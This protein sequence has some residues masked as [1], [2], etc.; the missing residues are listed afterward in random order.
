M[1][2]GE[3]EDPCLQRSEAPPVPSPAVLVVRPTRRLRSWRV[4]SAGL[5]MLVL[6]AGC[7]CAVLVA[8][9]SADQQAVFVITG[10]AALVS[11]VIGYVRFGL[12]HTLPFRVLAVGALLGALAL[13]FPPGSVLSPLTS[14]VSELVIAVGLACAIRVGAIRNRDNSTLGAASVEVGVV[15]A[16][17]GAWFVNALPRVWS[18]LFGSA[19]LIMKFVV[20]PGT[21]VVLLV[22]SVLLL[23]RL[24]GSRG[25][26][27][28]A[29]A[30]ALE[31]VALTANIANVA[32][33][34]TVLAGKFFVVALVVGLVLTALAFLEPS[35][36]DLG[37]GL[38][39]WRSRRSWPRTA[40]MLVIPGWVIGAVAIG[41]SSASD[42]VWP[43]LLLTSI[44]L[45]AVRSR[46]IAGRTPTAGARRTSEEAVDRPPLTIDGLRAWCRSMP[47][48]TGAGL[49][50]AVIAVIPEVDLD[51]RGGRAGRV[52]SAVDDEA[53]RRLREVMAGA[54]RLDPDWGGQWEVGLDRDRFLVVR[55]RPADTARGPLPRR[56]D[57]EQEPLPVSGSVERAA[58]AAARWLA[59]PFRTEMMSVRVDFGIGFAERRVGGSPDPSDVVQD[60][61]WAA[62]GNAAGTPAPFDPARRS[63]IRRRAQLAAL[64]DDALDTGSGLSV[65]YEPIVDLR[66]GRTVGAEALARWHPTDWGVVAPS[67]FIPIAEAGA[68]ILRLGDFVMGTS[69]RAAARTGGR[70]QIAVNVSGAELS[71]PDFY[72]RVMRVMADTGLEP[73]LLTIEITERVV[74][75]AVTQAADALRRLVSTGVKLAMDDFGTEASGL[76]RLLA[77]PWHSVKLDRSLV[78]G[79]DALDSPRAALIRS[80]LE[81]TGDLGT[82]VVAEGIEDVPTLVLVRDLGCHHAQ[83]FVFGRSSRDLREAWSEHHPSGWDLHSPIP[84]QWQRAG[85]RAGRPGPVRPSG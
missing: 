35:L 31:C 37:T 49:E 38:A 22:P 29:S 73:A 19:Y 77:L 4:A 47:A 43:L 67:E 25:P 48:E 32:A 2:R 30:F 45:L 5:R 78:D 3:A 85:A 21:V 9:G 26:V 70:H 6:T 84:P 12:L 23:A 46:L 69:C 76:L 74:D 39:R 64:L 36:I 72:G 44:G 57:A 13:A 42:V 68:S 63:A 7:V 80:V 56:S 59:L 71:H 51:G 18:H 53:L 62:Q 81:V 33:D 82:T 16:A 14:A 79:I 17:V 75:D 55:I 27:L 34:G 65:A 52:D 40:W 61:I 10:S 83:G 8:T 28:L 41:A 1:G 66:S 15:V 20:L 58:A 54:D 60:A 11:V 50:I 24:R